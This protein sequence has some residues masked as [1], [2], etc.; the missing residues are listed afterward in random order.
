MEQR[1]PSIAFVGIGT[2]RRNDRGRAGP[3]IPTADKCWYNHAHAG[4]DSNGGSSPTP[5]CEPV[6]WK[7]SIHLTLWNASLH[8]TTGSAIHTVNENLQTNEAM[9]P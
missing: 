9:C 4:A 2:P 1:V 6:P 5:D 7:A 8:R 3:P